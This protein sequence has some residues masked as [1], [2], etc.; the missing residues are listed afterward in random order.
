VPI[1]VS[2]P[3]SVPS[4]AFIAIAETLRQTLG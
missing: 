2:A 4:Q 1:V 3:K